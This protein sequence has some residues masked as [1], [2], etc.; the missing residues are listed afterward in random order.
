MS[1][2]L[3]FVFSFATK[4][5]IILAF[6]GLVS[7]VTSAQGQSLST[8][9]G[10]QLSSGPSSLQPADNSSPRASLLNFLQSTDTL[11]DLWAS[12]ASIHQQK[13][14][15]RAAVESFDFET[16]PYASSTSEQIERLL[17]ARQILA[18][19]PLPS[20]ETIPDLAA[21]RQGN[22]TGW[23]V[24]GT[25]LRMKLIGSG[26]DAGDFKF[27]AITI[28][29]LEL[30]YR[31]GQSMPRLD[32][33]VDVY[34]TYMEQG[35]RADLTEDQIA[36]RLHGVR[37]TSPRGT[38]EAF[39][40]NMNAAYDIAL[41]AE[42]KLDANPPQI[43][44][45]MALI[46]QAAAVD[47]LQQAVSVFDLSQVPSILR[48][49]TG[50]E[51]A[52]LLKEVLDR[53]PLPRTDAV[54]DAADL[55]HLVPTEAYHWRLPGTQIEIEL[56]QTGPKAGNYL[57]SASSVDL[58]R[59]S[60]ESL[61][62]LEYRREDTLNLSDS[63]ASAVTPGFYEYYS[64]TPGY[65]V[66][67]THFLG[68]LV[69]YFPNW[70][71]KVFYDQTLWQWGGAL[72]S[73][74]AFAVASWSVFR[75]IGRPARRHPDSVIFAWLAIAAPLITIFLT[76][77]TMHFIDFDIN[78][79]SQQ[80]GYL[81]FASG[82][83]EL[84]FYVLAVWRVSGAVSTTALASPSMSQRGF[85]ASLVRLLA[86]ILGVAFSVGV[87]S[88]GLK[89]LGVDIIPLLAGIGVGG[90]AVALA[91]RPT[92]ENLIG[93]LILFSDKPVRVGDFCTFG[94]MSGTVEDVGIRSTQIRAKDRTL[95]S[96]PNAKF[97]DMEII[98]WA[99]CDKMLIE[100]GIGLRYETSSDQLRHVL[101]SIREMLHAHPKI[102][103]ETVR[104]RFSGYGESSLNISLRIYALT[105]DWN[106]F[107]AIQED[108]N[109]HIKK[110]VEASGT[111]FAF[112]SQT[113]YMS[114]DTGLDPDATAQAEAEVTKWR[115]NEA[116]GFPRLTPERIESLRGTLEYPPKGSSDLA[117]AR[118]KNNQTAE[119]LS[120]TSKA[121]DT[122]P[123]RS[124]LR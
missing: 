86:G 13:L 62:D 72:L 35:T 120:D 30:D 111:G 70:T 105:C 98:N 28:E 109:F 91:I 4:F 114:K 9:A 118:A 84:S 97:V 60:Y 25:D 85:D 51:T 48:H 57:F 37:T 15:L 69:E 41:A 56:I 79:T 43:T 44:R 10:S 63:D 104:V 95:I 47:H 53:I 21:V 29:E 2:G 39:L 93:G 67:S 64:T 81:L 49:D 50:I 31:R 101:V 20:A 33:G 14:Y 103:G 16:T 26:R 59:P 107:H 11:L 94:G 92:L 76:R 80:L 115:E 55:T 5:F 99:M 110:L 113:L 124:D 1:L 89:Q 106:E 117:Q 71:Y 7:G 83:V 45:E 3:R 88:F 8:D 42:A 102:D 116:L 17:L 32:G 108:V 34:Q 78:F 68:N 18:R 38:L 121:L 75:V 77:K 66:P 96:V 119:P 123:V 100:G 40:L 46:E 73:L 61:R 24:P 82:L 22:I 122:A 87:A 74:A 90:L 54:P 65:L 23:T 6:V 52:L 12:G 27:D 58:M 112:P 19:V 36:T